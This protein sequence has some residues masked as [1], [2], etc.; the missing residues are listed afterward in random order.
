M[1]LSVTE[2]LLA[3]DP[4]RLPGEPRGLA[5]QLVDCPLP[6]LERC[7]AGRLV[8]TEMHPMKLAE[9]V[10]A[11]R[12]IG[13]DPIEVLV[14]PRV[15]GLTLVMPLLAF[16]ASILAVAGG[17]LFVWF[18][19]GIPPATLPRIFEPFFT[20]KEVGKGT[21]LGLAMVRSI[22]TKMGGSIDCESEVG[23]GTSFIVTLP[24][25]ARTPALAQPASAVCSSRM[26]AVV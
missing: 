26:R 22:V 4:P 19:L 7:D 18:D 16:Y 14:L 13:L 2:H 9:E 11:M 8:E 25:A 10:D 3:D 1:S 5:A 12:T 21:G 15:I 6:R 20:T 23:V 24:V 17:G